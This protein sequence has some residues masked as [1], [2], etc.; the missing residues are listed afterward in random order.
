LIAWVAIVLWVAGVSAVLVRGRR[1]EGTAD[2]RVAEPVP[3]R[4]IG[5]V[6]VDQAPLKDAV[7]ALSAAT[8]VPIE[9][10]SG[11]VDNTVSAEFRNISLGSALESLLTVFPDSRSVYTKAGRVVIERDGE[12]SGRFEVYPIDDLLRLVP[13]PEPLENPDGTR[14]FGYVPPSDLKGNQFAG[15][16]C[17]LAGV[18]SDNWLYASGRI[19][20]VESEHGHQM[21][22]FT[23]RLLRSSFK[24]SPAGDHY[25]RELKVAYQG[26]VSFGSTAL[27]DVFKWVSSATGASVVVDSKALEDRGIKSTSPVHLHLVDPTMSQMASAIVKSSGAEAF[28][29]DEERNVLFFSSIEKLQKHGAVV[30]IYDVRDVSEQAAKYVIAARSRFPAIAWRQP[31]PKPK[32]VLYIPPALKPPVSMPE[33]VRSEMEDSLVLFIEHAIDSDN[34]SDNGGVPGVIYPFKGRILIKTSPENHAAIERLLEQVGES[35]RGNGLR[36]RSTLSS[37]AHEK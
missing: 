35:L 32:N 10:P 5:L 18:D 36:V 7:A 33:V 26:E 9:V 8:G 27:G 19:I 4:Q 24:A 12:R 31:P 30:R 14:Q 17:A 6:R 23:L 3:E 25:S 21:V 11:P 15:V 29:F 16:I 22:R 28:D 1:V 20:M 37:S 13:E 34:W 2:A